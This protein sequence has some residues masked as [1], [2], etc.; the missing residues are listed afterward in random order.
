MKQTETMDEQLI[1][2]ILIMDVKYND[3]FIGDTSECLDETDKIDD[4]GNKN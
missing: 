2:I 4:Y 1:I 3:E